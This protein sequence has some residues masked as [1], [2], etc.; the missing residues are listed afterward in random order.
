MENLMFK[1]F[2]KWWNNNT[3]P[4]FESMTKKAI[5]EWAATKGIQLDRRETKEK[6]IE[7][8]NQLI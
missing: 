6:M 7:K 8:L 2:K 1:I 3:V 4:D 5:D